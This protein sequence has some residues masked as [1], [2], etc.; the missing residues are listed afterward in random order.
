MMMF[1]RLLSTI[2]NVTQ[3]ISPSYGATVVKCSPVLCVSCSLSTI[4]DGLQSGK[5]DYSR[6]KFLRGKYVVVPKLLANDDTVKKKRG[7]KRGP[8][9]QFNREATLAN[10]VIVTASGP[11]AIHH[12][13]MTAVPVTLQKPPVIGQSTSIS[14]FLQSSR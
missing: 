6:P 12:E 13:S 4:V 8:G 1:S 10:P 2:L 3:G 7:G 9:G 11:F 14:S 5:N